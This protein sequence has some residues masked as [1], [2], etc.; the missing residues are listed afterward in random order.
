MPCTYPSTSAPKRR[1][2]VWSKKKERMFARLPS[3]QNGVVQALSFSVSNA[4]L[5]PIN[6][7]LNPQHIAPQQQQ[8]SKLLTRDLVSVEQS[9][10][11]QGHVCRTRSPHIQQFSPW[12][13]K[14]QRGESHSSSFFWLSPLSLSLHSA[15]PIQASPREGLTVSNLVPLSRLRIG[16]GIGYPVW[17]RPVGVYS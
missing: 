7:L 12:L 6:C 4:T 14:K 11:V 9:K 13:Y 10:T 2:C 3:A 16:F 17:A 8:Q 5:H 1:A 15:P